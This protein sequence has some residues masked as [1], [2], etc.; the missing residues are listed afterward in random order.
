M[1]GLVTVRST[2]T[3]E[4][5]YD[6]NTISPPS[7]SSSSDTD[8]ENSKSFMTGKKI[9]KKIRKNHRKSNYYFPFFVIFFGIF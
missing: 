5:L 7:S 9:L 8:R 6:L 2:N 4:Y 3:G 1:K